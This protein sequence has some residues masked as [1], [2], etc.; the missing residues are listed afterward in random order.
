MYMYVCMHYV[1]KYVC[2][3]VWMHACLHVDMVLKCH[4]T[5]AICSNKLRAVYIV[6]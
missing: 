4:F 3:Y 5:P 1:C 2:M 6:L